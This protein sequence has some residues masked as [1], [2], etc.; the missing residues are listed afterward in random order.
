MVVQELR[1]AG[2]CMSSVA[3]MRTHAS[4]GPMLVV[5]IAGEDMKAAVK[6]TL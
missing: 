4:A 2:K 6:R 1:S 3:N 5:A